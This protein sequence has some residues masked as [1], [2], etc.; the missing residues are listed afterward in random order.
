MKKL[1][2]VAGARPNFMKIA[3]LIHQLKKITTLE[4]NLVHTGQHYDYKMSNAF[5]DDLDIPEPNYYLNVGS[6]S[7]AV[8][9]SKIMFEFEKVCLSYTPNL[10]LVVGDVNSTLACSIV[11]KKL[12]IKV[13]H[14]EAG[15]RS[16][17]R[18]MPEEINRIVTDSI[19]DYF[20]TTELSAQNNLL[21]EGINEKNIFYS[22]NLMIDTLYHGLRKIE[23]KEKFSTDDYGIVTLHRP[24]NVDDKLI[25]ED[26]IDVLNEISK[27]IKLYF[28]LH[29]RTKKSL[30]LFNLDR[31][32]SKTVKL[33]DPLSY[34][35]FIHMLKDAK[36]I[37]TDSGGI[38]EEATLLKIPC[39][40]FRFNT[41]R[42]ITIINGTN[43]LVGNQKEKI[44]KSFNQN[45]FNINKD[46]SIPKYWDGKTAKRIIETILKLDI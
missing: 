41:E 36:A 20:F 2:L 3:P 38:Q 14:V 15:L 43:V 40:T 9:T 18:E 26:L 24:S 23:M 8:Q 32:I 28:P 5:F 37:F 39:Y 1:L 25:L 19:S 31:K 46:Y 16:F 7:H 21:N 27:E 33:L 30:K 13:A 45:K 6:G 11:A 17:D 10:V 29:P 35:N 44:L 4:Y 22:G 12:N 42:P 34:I